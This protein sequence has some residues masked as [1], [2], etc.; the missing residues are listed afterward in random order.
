LLLVGPGSSTGETPTSRVPESKTT[1]SNAPPAASPAGFGGPV[2]ADSI[3]TRHRELFRRG[4]ALVTFNNNDCAEDTT[5]RN[6]DGSFAFRNTRFYPAYPGYDWGILA[7]WAWGTSRIADYLETD[8]AIDK[9]KLIITGASR[10]GKAA[11]V[12]AAFDDRLMGAPVVTGGGGIGAYRFSGIGRGGKEGLGEM[13]NKYPN[14]FSPN[15]HEFWGQT[16]KLPFDAHWFLALCAPRPFIALEGDTDTVSLPNAVK[17]AIL[18]AKPAYEF[19]GVPDRLGVNYAHHGHAF[20]QDDWNALLDFADK[21][22][23]GLKV[24]RHFDQFL[25]EPPSGALQ[26][27]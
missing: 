6:A 18:A 4:Y 1:S 3:A 14:W 11:M 21:H 10:A 27:E 22:L 24:D 5:L 16:D 25:P 7:G 23:R 2:T 17:Q 13:M 12:A 8:S 26:S 9:S 19:L 20:T 15:L